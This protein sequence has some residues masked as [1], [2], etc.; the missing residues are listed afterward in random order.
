M[1]ASIDTVPRRSLPFGVDQGI[2]MQCHVEAK[3][4]T[5]QLACPYGTHERCNAPAAILIDFV[6]MDAANRMVT[7]HC[8]LRHAGWAMRT[9]CK[10]PV[11]GMCGIRSDH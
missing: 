8:A 7:F 5:L 4:R 1:L 11:K 2:L 10:Q 3:P 9:F 6:K